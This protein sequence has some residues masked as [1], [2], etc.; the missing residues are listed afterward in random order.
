MKKVIYGLVFSALTYSQNIF[1]VDVED[2]VKNFIKSK[3]WV[4]FAITDDAMGR[5]VATRAATE[6]VRK[7]TTLTLTYPTVKSCG[8]MPVDLIIKLDAPVANAEHKNIFGSF[9]IDDHQPIEV[10][11]ILQN[12][13]D[14]QFL[15]ISAEVKDFEN[16]IKN[17]KSLIANFKGYGVME[18]SLLGATQ[19]TTNAKNTCKN[20]S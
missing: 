4:S 12:E 9:Q 5:V 7:N 13:E 14:S 11:A 16:R 10:K 15:F 18:F 19:A 20:F 2:N 8:L 3:D 6:D 1:A 17:S